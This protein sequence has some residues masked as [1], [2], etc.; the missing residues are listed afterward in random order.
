MHYTLVNIF[1]CNQNE[2]MNSMNKILYNK[3]QIASHV[4]SSYLRT[5]SNTVTKYEVTQVRPGLLT[6]K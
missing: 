3:I 5:P 2:C 4:F 6:G 1:P